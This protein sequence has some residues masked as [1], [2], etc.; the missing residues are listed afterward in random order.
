MHSWD[1]NYLIKI[2]FVFYRL[3]DLICLKGMNFS[4]YV[5]KVWYWCVVYFLCIIFLWFTYQGN[6]GLAKWVGIYFQFSISPSI[7]LNTFWVISILKYL[8]EWSQWSYLVL[9]FL[10]GKIFNY[11]VSYFNKYSVS[12]IFYSSLMSFRSCLSSDF[13]SFNL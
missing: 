2:Y 4:T 10:C 1:K 11:K 7:F 12:H 6:A 8:V 5:H 3:L 13:F 9:E